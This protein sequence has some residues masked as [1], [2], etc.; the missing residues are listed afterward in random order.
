[1]GHGANRRGLG[2]K[3]KPRGLPSLSLYIEIN[4]VF[5]LLIVTFVV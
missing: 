1:M 4:P 3:R 5:G 2:F